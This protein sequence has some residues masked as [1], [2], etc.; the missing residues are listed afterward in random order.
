M[1]NPYI[2]CMVGIPGSGKSTWALE[3]L[4]K[5]PNTLRVSRDDF[6]YMLKN[7]G[8][9]EQGVESMINTLLT[10]AVHTALER[11]YDVLVDNCHCKEKYINELVKSFNGLADIDFKTF[12]VPVDE[13]IRR[14]ALRTKTVGEDVIR[15][16]YNDYTTLKKNYKFNRIPQ[17]V[18]YLSVYMNDPALPHCILVDLDGTM[19]KMNGRS[20]YEWLRVDEDA[21][22]VPVVGLVRELWDLGWRVIFMSGRDAICREKTIAW[23]A[24]YMQMNPNRVE[25]YMR[26]EGDQRK[27]SII[28]KELFDQHIRNKFHVRF[29]LDDR[30][31]VVDVWRKEIGVPC[32][33][34][35][36]GNF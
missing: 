31:A 18:P 16:F 6:R 26:P 32:F 36:Y 20:P 5:Y 22:N 15:K 35:D 34:V 7:Q 10:K 19:A 29:V 13:C 4:A 9:C 30:D 11:G 17:D 1:K 3:Y 23:I 12:D 27:D 8:F 33:Q 25:L 24:K 2:L 28:K 21:P 14:D